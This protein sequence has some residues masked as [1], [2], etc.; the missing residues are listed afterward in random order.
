MIIYTGKKCH[1]PN[2]TTMYRKLIIL[3]LLLFTVLPGLFAQGQTVQGR[4]TGENGEPL[5]G[6]NVLV[7]GTTRG[8]I[9][10]PEGRYT[11]QT[12]ANSV[13]TFSF[14]GFESQDISVGNRTEINVILKAEL[15]SLDEI[16]VIGYGTQKRSHF[17]GAV[18]GISADK[19][20][21]DQIPVSR[22]DHAL[23]GKLAGVQIRDQ[24]SQVGEAPD[25]KIRGSASFNASNQP[26]IV[27]DGFPMVGGD[28]SDVDMSDVQSIEVLKDAASTAIYGSRG[29]NGVIMITTKKGHK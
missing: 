8:V 15:T 7:Q 18:A 5:P 20:K 14:V 6:T 11:I 4:V 19:E 23:Q 17:S 9:T 25:I 26:L 28:L 13:L 21:L 12:D 22:L 3:T 27:I 16:V 29:G 10:N 24:T 1:H 2:N